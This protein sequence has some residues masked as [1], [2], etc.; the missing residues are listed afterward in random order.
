M[1]LV[2]SPVSPR[3]RRL[4]PSS[5]HDWT[6]KLLASPGWA[7]TAASCSL[8]SISCGVFRATIR[9][10]RTVMEKSGLTRWSV[11]E[12]AVLYTLHVGVPGHYGLRCIAS[13]CD[14]IVCLFPHQCPTSCRA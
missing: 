14:L 2:I 7:V 11:D 13:W 4:S 8:M 6:V 5:A 9:L 3:G 1:G 10:V 12:L